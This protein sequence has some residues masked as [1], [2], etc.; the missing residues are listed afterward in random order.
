MYLPTWDMANNI[1]DFKNSHNWTNQGLKILYM[2]RRIIYL[3]W[4]ICNGMLKNDAALFY[5]DPEFEICIGWNAETKND[6]SNPA[7]HTHQWFLWMYFLVLNF[8]LFISSVEKIKVTSAKSQLFRR[9]R[10]LFHILQ[11][12]TS[13][14]ILLFSLFVDVRLFFL[15]D[16][17]LYSY[18]LIFL[19][20]IGSVTA[21][22]PEYFPQC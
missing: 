13:H 5:F 22:K 14:I 9:A 3:A 19:N 15:P 1:L 10:Y 2:T 8:F 7:T 4:E 11:L 21:I 17:L 20:C 6:S 16:Y 18:L 12:V